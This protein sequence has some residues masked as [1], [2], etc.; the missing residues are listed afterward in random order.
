MEPS[1]ESHEQE[2]IMGRKK[3]GEEYRSASEV[4]DAVQ[5]LTEQFCK[6]A[7]DQWDQLARHPV[8]LSTMAAAMEQSLNLMA[9]VQELVT[10]TLKTMNLPTRDDI[11]QL[12]SSVEAL[13]DEVAEL[14]RKLEERTTPPPR[15]T[16]AKKKR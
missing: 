12:R 11:E 9:R 8:F 5:Q 2:G 10:T 7:A 14:H 3:S 6:S 4:L 13:R 15:K 16:R 1:A